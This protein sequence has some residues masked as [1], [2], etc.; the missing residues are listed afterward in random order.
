M[1]LN[2]QILIVALLHNPAK[3]PKIH[4]LDSTKLGYLLTN[5][6]KVDKYIFFQRF[7]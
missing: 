6:L 1:L 4:D 2:F 7:K 5:F 3:F